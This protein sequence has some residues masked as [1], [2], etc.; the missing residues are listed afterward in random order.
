MSLLVFG[1]GDGG[2][3]PLAKMLENV[4][5][6]DTFLVTHT[7][8]ADALCSAPSYPCDLEPLAGHPARQHGAFRGRVLRCPREGLKGGFDAAKLVSSLPPS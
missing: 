6:N 8:R 5:P 2:G 1:N 4:S 7:D 3:G